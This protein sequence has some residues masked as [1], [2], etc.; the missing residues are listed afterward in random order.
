MAAP[1]VLDRV[2][3][4]QAVERFTAT[5]GRLLVTGSLSA[6]T[7]VRYRRDLAEFAALAGDDTILD[8]LSADDLDDIVA[9]YGSQP[10]HRFTDPAGRTRGPGTTA[11]FK[12]KTPPTTDV[13][14]PN[15][16]TK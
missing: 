14:S 12:V 13:P 7:A 16:R 15:W 9:T 10:D 3:V 5:F 8:D 2:S 6:T 1:P 4:A 11:R